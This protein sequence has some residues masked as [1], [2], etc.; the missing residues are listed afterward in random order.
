MSKF[1]FLI[2]PVEAKEDHLAQQSSMPGPR[3]ANSLKRGELGGSAQHMAQSMRAE[4]EE[5]TKRPR[6]DGSFT[7]RL[8]PF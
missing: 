6:A 1:S 8:R 4:E 3:W 7:S 2:G 5:R